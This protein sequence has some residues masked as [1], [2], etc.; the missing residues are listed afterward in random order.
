MMLPG[1]VEN[2]VCIANINSLGVTQ[3]PLKVGNKVVSFMQSNYRG[4]L[5]KMFIVNAPFAVSMAYNAMKGILE[6][7]T[8]DKIKLTSGNKLEDIEKIANLSQIEKKFNGTLPDLTRFWPVSLPDPSSASKA[9]PLISREE[10]QIL[11]KKGL[12]KN[13]TLCKTLIKE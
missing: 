5:F 1:Q 13:N 10:Y 8:R 11:H 6:E 7:A 4:R 9:V 3:L 2:W 12:L